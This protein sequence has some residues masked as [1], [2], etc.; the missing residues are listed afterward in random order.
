VRRHFWDNGQ[1]SLR[2]LLRWQRAA[3]AGQSLAEFAL[4]IPLFIA[5]LFGSLEIGMALKTQ[6]AY[7][8]AVQEAT[9]VAAAAGGAGDADTQAL[10]QLQRMLT[11]EN[12]RNITKVTIYSAHVD[13]SYVAKPL[14][15]TLTV[16]PPYCVAPATCFD[17]LHTYY[18]YS[19]SLKRF[20]CQNTGQDAPCNTG[21]S[22]E[23][24]WDPLGRSTTV[25]SL[26]HI[27]I[28]VQ[29]DYR[30]SGKELEGV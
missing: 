30:P 1:S 25:G 10:V 2:T 20:V 14:C 17:N 29:Y 19:P 15:D 6:A 26:D 23:S 21:A 7:Q 9:R 13:G 3:A 8:E 27:G 11:T 5:L 28:T 12:M 4:V 18:V 22:P 24:Y 16:C